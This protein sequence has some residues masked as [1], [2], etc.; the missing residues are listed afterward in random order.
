MFYKKNF[1]AWEGVARIA[2]AALM[3]LCAVRYAGTPAGWAFGILGAV[4][5]ATALIGFFVPC[6]PSPVAN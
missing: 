5:A 3:F 2:G 1:P 6:V 4:F